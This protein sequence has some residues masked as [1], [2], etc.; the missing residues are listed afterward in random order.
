VYPP[1]LAALTA[2][3]AGSHRIVHYGPEAE[4]L[5]EL[6]LPAGT[7]PAPVVALLHGGYWRR[8]YR[9]D[10]MH[11]LA[12]DLVA[13]GYAA[14]NVEF[15]R[16]GSPGGGFPGTFQ[17]VAA[18]LDILAEQ[19]TDG[20][21]DLTRLAAVG[22][23]AGGPLALWTAARHR[24]PTEDAAALG[25]APGVGPAFVVSL[26]GVCD[27]AEAARRRLSD[28]AALLLLGGGPAERPDAYRLTDPVR[29][30]PLGVPTLVVHGTEDE[31]VPINLTTSYAAAAGAECELLLL[32]GVDH[33]ALIEP[34]SAAWAT[35]AERLAAAL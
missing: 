18:A 23:S 6:W 15:R 7:G 14:W 26:A 27:L 13:R 34:T 21:L 28:G 5:G 33:M 17:D 10:L 31:D 22:H 29:L 19:A 8:R 4:Q 16:I 24:L 30:L 3:P 25:G 2:A 35:V 9:L 20:R 1:R 11:A 12:A 32:P